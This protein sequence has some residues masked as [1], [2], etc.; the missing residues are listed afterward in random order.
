M[1]QRKLIWT[2]A[3]RADRKK[4]FSYWTNR[5][6]S[7]VYS[8]RLSK[9]FLAVGEGLLKNHHLGL[10]TSKKDLFYVV[11]EKKFLMTYQV[12]PETIEIISV[13]DGRRNPDDFEKLI[14]KR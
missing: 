13:W 9:V 3:A 7:G 1:V 2:E 11:V 4:I 12:K 8:K 6:K 14:I 10:K 5:N